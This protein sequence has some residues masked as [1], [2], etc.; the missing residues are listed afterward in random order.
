MYTSYAVM[1]LLHTYRPSFAVVFLIFV[2]T[3]AAR[4]SPWMALLVVAG[5]IA[6][7]FLDCVLKRKAVEKFLEEETTGWEQDKE[8]SEYESRGNLS[9]VK[10]TGSDQ[11]IVTRIGEMLRRIP[12]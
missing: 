7:D 8:D 3:A 4:F 9:R 11:I 6:F 2:G 12:R 5:Y 10:L 1:Y